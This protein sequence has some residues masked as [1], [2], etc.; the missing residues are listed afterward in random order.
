MAEYLVKLADE[1]GHTLEQVENARSEAELRDRFAQQGY[2]IY[3]LKPRGLLGGAELRLTGRRR[4]KLGQFV[5]FNQQFLTL[6]RA[7]LPIVH[8]LELLIKRQRNPFFRG[9]LENVRERVKSGELLSEAFAHQG[10]FPKI[11][12]TTLL[13]GEKSGSLVRSSTATS[14]TRSSRCRSGRNSSCR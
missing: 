11:Y 10:V 9:V 2:V 12:T 4:I 1:R 3:S 13:A 7:G 6:I 8:A 14:P 5:I